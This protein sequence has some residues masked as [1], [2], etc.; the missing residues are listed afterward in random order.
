MLWWR[1]D[2]KKTIFIFSHP[3]LSFQFFPSLLPIFPSSF[4]FPLIFLSPQP[5]PSIGNLFFKAV[6]LY[7]LVRLVLPV[8]THKNCFCNFCSQIRQREYFFF[9]EPE[10]RRREHFEPSV[11]IITES[12]LSLPFLI[13]SLPFLYFFSLFT[14]LHPPIYFF[15]LSVQ[16][17]RKSTRIHLAFPFHSFLV[18]Q[19]SPGAHKGRTYSHIPFVYAFGSK[20]DG[21][22]S[23]WHAP[24]RLVCDHSD[25]F[26]LSPLPLSL[27]REE[28]SLYSSVSFSLSPLSREESS[29]SSSVSFSLFSSKTN[30]S[31]SL[32]S[33]FYSCKNGGW[34]WIELNTEP[35]RTGVQSWRANCWGQEEEK[36]WRERKRLGEKK[37]RKQRWRGKK[38]F[39]TFT[40]DLHEIQLKN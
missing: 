29:L 9:G 5:N 35:E 4:S 33:L 30:L 14:P 28:S 1:E 27:S 18:T 16:C 39:G 11:I 15:L 2:G 20:V 19:K 12:L 26:S 34:T 40:C 21:K 17:T 25:H 13:L 3:S 37:K 24:S 10:K 22:F 38:N 8:A 6:D 36:M 23:L 32:F 7:V 31:L